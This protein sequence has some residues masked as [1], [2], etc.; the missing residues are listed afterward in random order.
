MNVKPLLDSIFV[1]YITLHGIYLLLILI[2]I[3][4]LRRYHQGINFGE[5]QRISE[6]ALTLPVS[7]VMAAHDEE[8]MIINTVLGALRLRYPQHEV[9]VVND[10]STDRTL[11]ILIEHFGLRRIDKVFKKHFQTQPIRGIYESPDYPNLVVVDKENGKRADALN[12]GIDLARYPLICQIDA[13]CI[14]EE[15]ALLRMVRPFLVNSQTI[16]AA[17]IVRPSNGLVIED[18]RIVHY[19]LP[20]RWLPLFQVVEYLRS[21]QWARLGLA[22]LHSMLSISGAFTMARKEVL[23]AIGG[24]DTK[25]ITD[26]FE[27]AVSLNRYVCENKQKGRLEIAY[28]P[29]PVCYSEVPERVRIHASQ[30]NR[31]QR[32]VLQSLLKNWNMTLNP[33][34]GLTGLFGMPFFLLFEGFSAIVEGLSY[35]L[36]PF[37]YFL[38][39]ATLQEV[40]LFLVF[41]V[42]LGSFISVSAVLLEE[43]TRLRQVT[44]RDLI[45][46]LVAGFLENFGYH[47]MHLLWRIGGT[48][49]YF[50]RRR[51][52]FGLQERLGYQESK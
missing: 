21:F 25:S 16:A 26:D 9:V 46:I 36:I 1:Y 24:F 12:A 41:A 4:Q 35:I 44:T 10:G 6:S 15:D 23:I 38:G 31:W 14:M 32:G 18:G 27:L 45:R 39:V 7:V 34:Y 43:R 50:I 30:R 51:T 5:F 37:T 42:V 22:R 33:R 29:D 52:D 11:E 19:G 13:D 17:G 20:R 40:A 49:D 3:T 28:I 8:K 47:Q 48:F 2:G